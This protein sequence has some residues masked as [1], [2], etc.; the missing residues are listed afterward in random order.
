[1]RVIILAAGEGSRLRPLTNHQ[2]KCMV[3]VHDQALL[4]Y[5]LAILRRAGLHE[6]ILVKG[7]LA[8]SFHPP[9][10]RTYV[11][12]AF[13]STNMVWTLFCARPEFNDEVIVSYGD[14]VYPLST[15]Q[16]LLASKKS[17]C[18]V[19]DKAWEVYWRSR[20][21][22]PLADAESLVLDEVGRIVDI[23]QRPQSIEEIQ[24]QYIGLMKFNQ[25]GLKAMCDVFDQAIANGTLGGKDPTK[26]Y[27]T[28]LLQVLIVK[29]HELWPIP[30]EGGWVEVD[31]V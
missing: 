9:V 1:M 23:G 30:I 6:I 25:E 15:I 16:A 27:M 19:I 7:Y 3:K 4:D 8:D 31:S 11:N 24:G 5:Q 17:I 26:A 2:P 28:D 18:V 29:G 13:K 21:Q 20:F 14:I 22:N 12:E 10:T